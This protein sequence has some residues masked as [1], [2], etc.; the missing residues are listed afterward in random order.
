MDLI[1][2]LYLSSC[3]SSRSSPD[4]MPTMDF[5]HP[6]G[7]TAGSP[8][9]TYVYSTLL[10]SRTPCSRRRRCLGRFQGPSALLWHHDCSQELSQ[11]TLALQDVSLSEEEDLRLSPLS[12]QGDLTTRGIYH[13]LLP[14]SETDPVHNFIWKNASPPKFKF[15]AWLLSKDRLPTAKN[16]FTKIILQS[17][18]CAIC[19]TGEETSNHLFFMCPFATAF[20]TTIRVPPN[21]TEVSNIHLL[22]RPPNIPSKHFKTFYLLS[23]WGLWNRRHD[24]VFRDFQPS[25]QRLILRCKEESLLWAERLKIKDRLEAN[26]WCNI[27]SNSLSSLHP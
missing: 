16:L 22:A 23:F 24:V 4:R 11:L 10:S 27:F 5:A 26:V 3:P 15:F 21:V 8:T 7:M 20:W 13:T 17:P 2:I 9:N 25:V 19:Q 12:Q 18:Q 6:F 14:P 1:G